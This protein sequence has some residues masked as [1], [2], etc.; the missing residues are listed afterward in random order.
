MKLKITLKLLFRAFLLSGT[1]TFAS[2]KAFCFQADSVIVQSEELYTQGKYEEAIQILNER[3]KIAQK[4]GEKSLEVILYNGIGKAYSQLGKSIQALQNYQLAAKLAELLKD[5]L[6]LG[7]IEKNI[8]ALYEEQKDFKQA[9]EHYKLAD[10]IA[11][12]IGDEGLLADI[13]N[14]KGIIYEQQLNYPLALKTYQK[15]LSSYQKIGNKSRMA[16]SLNN[17]GIV[18]KYLG[19][20]DEAIS[21]YKKSLKYSEEIGDKFFVAAN[22]N[23]IG[24]VYAMQKNYTKAIKFNEKSLAISK[25]IQATNIVVEALSSLAEDFAGLGNYKK[26]YEMNNEYLK[27][28]SD[29]INLESSKK[30]AEM[31]TLYQTEKQQRQISNLR[32]LEQINRLKLDQQN[33]LIQ[34]RNYQ[35]FFVAFTLIATFAV[36]YFLFVKH[37][38]TQKIM[39]ERAVKDAQNKERSRIAQDVH[40]DIGSGLSKISLMA[41]VASTYMRQN[42]LES[43]E[44]IAISQVSKDLVE[45]MRDLIWVLNPENATL[46][47]LVAR[48]REYCL[49]YLEG[50]AVTAETDIQDDIPNITISQQVQRNIFLTVKEA[51]NNC[52]K[53][54]DC[55]FISI[56]LHYVNQELQISIA[57]KGKGFDASNLNKKGNGLT[58]MKRRIDDIGGT[59]KVTSKQQCGT[60]IETKIALEKLQLSFT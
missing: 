35:I 47:S 10:S 6:S 41:S 55:N 25:E 53:H 43:R 1:I 23:N 21:Y 40:D 18:Y 24:N 29:Y 16:L 36:G 26:A 19:K 32:Q 60:T 20:Y 4:N 22:L 45:N 17:I 9:L 15:A 49:D 31:Q 52:I 28:N 51:L 5:Q 8:G 57:D 34:K 42:G 30:L 56:K 39:R 27:A 50:S 38:Q 48:I 14:N 46:D 2:Q 37:Q 58:N 12:N 54:A 59:F 11:H 13:N 3:L 44:I 33:Q 7:K